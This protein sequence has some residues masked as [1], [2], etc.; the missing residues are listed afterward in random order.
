MTTFKDQS[1]EERVAV[2]GDVGENAFREYAARRQLGVVKYGLDRPPVDLGRTSDFVR[3][4]PDFLTDEG[5]VEVQ[6]CGTDQLFKFKHAKLRALLLWQKNQHVNLWLWNQPLDDWRLVPM[7]R[8]AELCNG[9]VGPGRYVAF[10]E[11]GVFDGNKPY[12]SVSWIELI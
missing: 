4:T 7:T 6:G 8:I 3:Y 12:A 2:L 9:H 10:R 5:L 1:W 11:D